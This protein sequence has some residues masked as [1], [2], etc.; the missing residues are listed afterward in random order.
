MESSANVRIKNRGKTML[1]KVLIN[2]Y[3]IAGVIVFLLLLGISIFALDLSWSEA[4]LG[5]AA[6]TVVGIIAVW[7]KYYF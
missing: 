4:L 7:W 1:K 2:P 6:L 5:S 3:V